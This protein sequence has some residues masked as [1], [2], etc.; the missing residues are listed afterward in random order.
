MTTTSTS[1]S[2][3]TCRGCGERFRAAGKVARFTPCPV[4]PEVLVPEVAGSARMI[5]WRPSIE[6]K[7]GKGR[8]TSHECD[9]A[10]RSAKREACSCECGGRNHGANLGRAF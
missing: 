2:I 10:C 6:W 1:F 9:G 5:S 7:T 4:C 3:G 8:V